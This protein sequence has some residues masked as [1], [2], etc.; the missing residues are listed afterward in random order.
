M[1][2][3]ANKKTIKTPDSD[4]TA[5]HDDAELRD[6]TVDDAVRTDTQTSNKSGKHS[7]VEKLTASRPE[8]GA[9]PGA[10]PVPGA[11]GNPQE[12]EEHAPSKAHRDKALRP[13]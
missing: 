8:F 6:T 13:K 9:S 3:N 7:S 2:P 1:E 10:N 5:R 4:E 12:D 11:F